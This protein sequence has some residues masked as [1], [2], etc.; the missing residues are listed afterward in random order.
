MVYLLA[1]IWTFSFF[2]ITSLLKVT[3]KMKV[4]SFFFSAFL[5]LA[6]LHLV[7]FNSW[8][9]NNIVALFWCLS[10]L[11]IYLKRFPF[12]KYY[13]LVYMIYLTIPFV[14]LVNL[15]IKMGPILFL[16][17]LIIVWSLDVFSYIFGVSFGKHPIAPKISPKKTWEGTVIG[18]LFSFFLSLSLFHFYLHLPISG[19]LIFISF[20]VPFLGFF[21]DLFESALKRSVYKK[22]SG[23]FLLGHGGFLDRFDSLLFAAVVYSVLIPLL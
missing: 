8:I 14:F 7:S 18:L 21:G 3:E 15:R 22:D 11:I 4:D 23:D 20:F 19:L 10:T 1:V 5:F 12:H 16:L 6:S 13:P 17:L 9:F 2:E